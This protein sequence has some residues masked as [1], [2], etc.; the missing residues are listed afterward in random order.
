[1]TSRAFVL[2]PLEHRIGARIQCHV[3]VVRPRRQELTGHYVER[4][5]SSPLL[6]VRRMEGTRACRRVPV[7]VSSAPD[8][9]DPRP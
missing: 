3:I 9:E 2:P 6:Q 7:H 8:Q 1:M 5:L 4:R